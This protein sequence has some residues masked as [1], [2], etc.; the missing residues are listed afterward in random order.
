M[1]NLLDKEPPQKD[2]ELGACKRNQKII[3]GGGA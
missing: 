3:E 2:K 1:T